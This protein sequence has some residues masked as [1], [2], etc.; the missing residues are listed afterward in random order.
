MN[1]KNYSPTQHYKA[2]MSSKN[3]KFFIVAEKLFDQQDIEGE[4]S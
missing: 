1:L 3:F 2:K 4:N